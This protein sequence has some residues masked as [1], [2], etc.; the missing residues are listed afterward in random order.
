MRAL[1]VGSAE[2]VAGITLDGLAG[3]ADAE[4][5]LGGCEDDAAVGVVPNV[6][7]VLAHDGELDAVD[8]EELGEGQ[9]EGRGGEDIDLDESLAAGVVGAEGAL[10]SPFGGEG[11]EVL[12]QAGILPDPGV[13][14][15][16]V[17]GVHGFRGIRALVGS[18]E[19]TTGR[20]IRGSRASGIT[21]RVPIRRRRRH[22]RAW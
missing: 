4:E 19:G 7:F 12:R 18:G 15:R 5:A 17:D 9:A 1:A 8:R 3:E 20:C 14:S 10:P 13:G 16:S 6:G 21:S 11:G 22:F 2:G